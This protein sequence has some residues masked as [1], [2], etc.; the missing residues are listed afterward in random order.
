MENIG[1]AV[2]LLKNSPQMVTLCVTIFI[3]AVVFVVLIDVVVGIVAS[4]VL[5][6]TVYIVVVL[7]SLV[8]T[9][10]VVIVVLTPL[11]SVKVETPNVGIDRIGT[12]FVA[13]IVT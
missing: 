5:V 2:D 13:G 1:G 4:K 8:G 3:K 10:S 9:V 7:I 12:V 6:V 11:Y